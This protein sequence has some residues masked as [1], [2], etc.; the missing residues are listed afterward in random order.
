MACFWHLHNSFLLII[1]IHTSIALKKIPLLLA[2]SY[3]FD[4]QIKQP[5]MWQIQNGG[6]IG[7]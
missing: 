3:G 2:K 6:S 4:L 1:L 7:W 5:P